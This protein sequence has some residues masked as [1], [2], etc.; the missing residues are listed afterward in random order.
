ML[1]RL[2]HQGEKAAALGWGREGHRREGGQQ[3]QGLSG[4]QGGDAFKQEKRSQCGC[5]RA[6][7]DEARGGQRP[8]PTGPRGHFV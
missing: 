5:S 1:A 3:V 7:P 2:S 4:R 8:R 6:G